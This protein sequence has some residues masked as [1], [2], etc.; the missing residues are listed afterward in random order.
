MG[1]FSSRLWFLCFSLW[2]GN[3][4]FSARWVSLQGYCVE[5]RRGGEGGVAT[6]GLYFPIGE[7]IKKLTLVCFSYNCVKHYKPYHDGKLYHSIFFKRE[8]PSKGEL[9]PLK[10]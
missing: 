9:L 7:Q 8:K 5:A 10:E 4:I 1:I 6:T 3:S 2:R